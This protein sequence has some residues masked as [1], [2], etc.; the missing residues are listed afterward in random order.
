M[1]LTFLQ[2][3]YKYSMIYSNWVV[4]LISDMQDSGLWL[5]DPF[6]GYMT[7]ISATIQ[8]EQTLNKNEALANAAKSK[9]GKLHEFMRDMSKQCPVVSVM[10]CF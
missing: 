10:V 7:A 2:K 8:L 3:S 1:P 6:V 9:F 5:Y 4:R